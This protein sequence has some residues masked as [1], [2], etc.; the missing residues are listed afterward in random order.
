MIISTQI[1]QRYIPLVQANVKIKDLQ[2][3][4]TTKNMKNLK[5]ETYVLYQ[6]YQKLITKWSKSTER[7][8]QY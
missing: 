6:I 7:E 3:Q 5:K 1:Y 4:W 2:T 8:K